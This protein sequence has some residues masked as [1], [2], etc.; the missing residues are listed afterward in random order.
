MPSLPQALLVAPTRVQ[1]LVYQKESVSALKA[2]EGHSERLD[3]LSDR[4]KSL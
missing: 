3:T 2:L 4:K 1:T